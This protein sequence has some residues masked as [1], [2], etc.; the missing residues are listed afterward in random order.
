[1]SRIGKNRVPHRPAGAGSRIGHKIPIVAGLFCAQVSLA[2]FSSVEKYRSAHYIV[3]I[4][5]TS[6]SILCS[7]WGE[8]FIFLFIALPIPF[9]AFLHLSRYTD[10]RSSERSYS[11]AF[12]IENLYPDG[13][14]AARN[15]SSGG[16]NGNSPS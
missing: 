10:F 4:F 3:C 12:L 2:W 15:K 1:M 7:L 11:F 5:L 9:T 6:N 8:M 16:I 13:R 14:K